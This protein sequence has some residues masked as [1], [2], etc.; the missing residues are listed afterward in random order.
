[1]TPDWLL[2]LT[3]V[4]LQTLIGLRPTRPEESP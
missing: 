2:L 1:M 3:L 4:V